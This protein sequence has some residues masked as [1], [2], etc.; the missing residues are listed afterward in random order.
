MMGPSMLLG[1]VTVVVL[2]AGSDT[3]DPTTRAMVQALR[4]ALGGDAT[5]IVQPAPRESQDA[6]DALGAV[7]ARE[8]ANLATSV[9]WADQHRRVTV[10]F[11]RPADPRSTSERGARSGEREIV[12]DG[13]DAARERGRAVGFAIA[14]M[15]TEDEHGAESPPPEPPRPPAPTPAP[16]SPPTAESPPPL[17]A[18]SNVVHASLEACATAASAVSGYGGGG[19]LTL[20]FRREIVGAFALRAAATARFGEVGPASAS[21]RTGIA[22]VG[23]SWLPT[24]DRQRRWA[25]GARI[26]ALALWQEVVHLSS[27]DEAPVHAGRLVPGLD[28]ALE[29]AYRF[30]PSAAFVVAVGGETTFGKTDVYVHRRLVANLAPV[31]GISEVG[32]RLAF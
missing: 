8:H 21:T 3:E 24:I 5:V 16:T 27:D 22:A 17:A 23:V 9:G 19:G 13:N 28:L 15:V 2:V 31:R 25:V 26:D 6:N 29:G 7:A 1:V 32:L 4:A 18:P 14:S 30:T 12:F 10:R 11:V 20:A